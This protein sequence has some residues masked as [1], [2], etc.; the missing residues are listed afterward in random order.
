MNYKK[1]IKDLKERNDKLQEQYRLRDI[2]CIHL[3]YE[4]EMLK[5]DFEAQ[6]ELTK[7]YSK[8]NKELKE[9]LEKEYNKGYERGIL[10]TVEENQ[11]L[12]KENRE[13]KKQ[14]EYLR[15]GEYYNQ[16][17]FERDMLQNVVDNGE[18]SKEDKEFIDM[19][20][21]NTELLEEN[22]KLKKLLEEKNKHQIFI[23]TQDMEERYAEGLYQ[24]YL[25]EENKKYKNQQKEFIEYLEKTIVDSKAGSGQQYYFQEI[26]SKYKEIIGE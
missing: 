9:E 16:L 6:H 2:R 12:D 25:E 21:R 15:S 1:V 26:L 18:V 11:R 10:D 24:D 20:Q 22:Q 23:D 7:K 8:E 19:T 13:L 3:E 14:L 17:R 5:G 4:N